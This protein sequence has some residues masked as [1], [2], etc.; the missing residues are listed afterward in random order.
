MKTIFLKELVPYSIEYLIKKMNL[1]E[2]SFCNFMEK[3]ELNKILVYKASNKY[4]F[5]YVGIIQYKHIVV[6]FIPKYISKTENEIVIKQILKLFRVYSKKETLDE[7]EFMSL[8]NITQRDNTNLISIIDFLVADYI[9]HG[10]YRNDREINKYNGHGEI[11]WQRT[12][13]K[14]NA[15]ILN[16]QPVYLGYYTKRTVI[17]E[18]D[19]IREVHKYALDKSTD[20]MIQTGLLDYFGYPKIKYDI[21]KSDLGT[22]EYILDKIESE[23]YAQYSDRKQLLLIALY[24]FIAR[25][26]VKSSDR[27]LVMYGTRNFNIVWEKINKFVFDDEYNIYKEFIQKPIWKDN[28]N[29]VLVPSDERRNKTLEPDILKCIN[30]RDKS[31]FFIIDAK[32]YNIYF[33]DEYVF[34]NPG[35][36]DLTKQYLYQLALDK[37][38][39]EKEIDNIYNV[40]IFPKDDLDEIN[41][42]GEVAV[43]FLKDLGLN[44]IKLVHLPAYKI[45]DLYINNLKYNKD[46]MNT[47]ADIVN[48]Y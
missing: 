43:P 10:L 45:I 15:Y 16:N 5:K 36:S 9:N 25:E 24:S 1:S 2:D 39:N 37:L 6:Y 13:S 29:N 34:N 26:K 21:S 8:G 17:D 14:C 40:L 20:F 3:L 32:Y 46:S 38:C 41:K 47:F 23:L 27:S 33:K 42:L 31:I 12:I 22:T 4:V 18:E 35:I 7:E 19:Y 44:N 48:N 11:N 28:Y 30:V